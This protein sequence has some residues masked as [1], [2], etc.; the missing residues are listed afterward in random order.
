MGNT[1]LFLDAPAF[2]NADAYSLREF[3]FPKHQKMPPSCPA[4]FF[5]FL[6]HRVK[7]L[8]LPPCY[9]VLPEPLIA[10]AKDS[11]TNCADVLPR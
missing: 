2:G 3:L 9:E 8:G 11:A 4:L 1:E 7:Y 10:R 6:R 5:R